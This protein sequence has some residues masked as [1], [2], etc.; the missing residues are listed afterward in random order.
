MTS[1]CAKTNVGL[2]LSP[3]FTWF[4]TDNTCPWATTQCNTNDCCQK[5]YGPDSNH[6]FTLCFQSVCKVFCFE[7][8]SYLN[9]RIK[10][11]EGWEVHYPSAWVKSVYLDC[12][13][14]ECLIKKCSL[15]Q[16]VVV[17]AFNPSILEAEAGGFLS[18]RPAWSTKWV[19]GQPGLHRET[20]FW[21]NKQSNKQTNKM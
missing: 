2:C 17:H 12:N 16:A 3:D 4:W 6:T 20:L 13:L 18:S 15:S 7:E 19:P 9:Y 10:D 8:T 5:H 11:L 1:E 14:L 21:T